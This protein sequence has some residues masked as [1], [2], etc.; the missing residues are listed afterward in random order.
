MFALFAFYHSLFRHTTFHQTNRICLLFAILLS[1][2]VPIVSVDV[3]A[4]Q[5]V[6]LVSV[7]TS[8]YINL[9]DAGEGVQQQ[10]SRTTDLL[11]SAVI[12]VYL[13]GLLFFS[14]RFIRSMYTLYKLAWQASVQKH[15]LF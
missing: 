14:Y 7:M 2:I 12:W 3:P 13:I 5:T 4:K 15:K 10:A 9:K 6:P 1:F 11:P 8:P